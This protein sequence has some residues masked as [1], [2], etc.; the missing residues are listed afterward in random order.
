MD[1]PK[2]RSITGTSIEVKAF[3]P[4]LLNFI[5]FLTVTIIIRSPPRFPFPLT[6]IFVLFYIPL[7]IEIDYLAIE[8]FCPVPLQDPQDYFITF[9]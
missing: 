9:P 4:Y 6:R 2:I 1:A 7:G 5:L 3:K 8:F